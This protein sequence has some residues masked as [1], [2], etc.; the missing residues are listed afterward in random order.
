MFCRDYNLS[1]K[2][3]HVKLSQ[4]FL[5]EECQIRHAYRLKDLKDS[6][7]EKLF[8]SYCVELRYYDDNIK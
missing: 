3:I 7:T 1:Y 2:T 8:L 4:I 6:I 5:N